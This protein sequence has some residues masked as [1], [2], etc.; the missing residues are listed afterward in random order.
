[1]TLAGPPTPMIPHLILFFRK[2]GSIFSSLARS[3]LPAEFNSEL[4]DFDNDYLLC[5][6]RV[7][8]RGQ[9][10]VRGM[11]RNVNIDYSPALTPTPG[12]ELII[13]I[14][15]GST[16]ENQPTINRDFTLGATGNEGLRDGL[17]KSLF[18]YWNCK[19]VGLFCSRL[20]LNN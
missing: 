3:I 2:S 6:W 5:C 8:C 7:Y 4:N 19:Y 18:K 11:L 9:L 1:M 15:S 16:S 20:L 14:N 10:T 12:S 13:Y 17:F